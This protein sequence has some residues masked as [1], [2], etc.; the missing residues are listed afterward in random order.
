MSEFSLPT[1]NQRVSIMGRTGSGKTVAGVWLLSEAPFDRQPYIIFDYK[2]DRLLQSIERIEEIDLRETPRK[3]GLYKV[4]PRPEIDDDAVND[5]LWRQLDA[6]DRGLFFDEA[7]M[8]PSKGAFNA[9]LTQGRSKNI[10]V[11][12]LTQRPAFISRFVFTE[13][14]H[15]G[16]FHLNDKDDWKKV[17]RFVPADLSKR[18]PEFHF[19]W[20][21]VGKHSLFMMRPVPD[22]DMLLERFADRLQPKRR[23]F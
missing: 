10:P 12:A 20:Y 23:F 9:I 1:V 4:S 6:E 11:I 15:F 16:V 3:P 14:D 19:H 17:E 22:T 5:F 7:Y 13:S 8:I 21:D 2:R 18:K